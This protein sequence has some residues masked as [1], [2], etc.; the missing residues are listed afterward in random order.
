MRPIHSKLT[1]HSIFRVES[2]HSL[3]FP[4]SPLSTSSS[5]PSLPEP[6]YR[7]RQRQDHAVMSTPFLSST[8]I[9][10]QHLPTY[11]SFSHLS[12]PPS[13]PL[14]L[15]VVCGQEEPSS[16]L[17]SPHLFPSF[18][19]PLPSINYENPSPPYPPSLPKFPPLSPPLL[20]LLF[21]VIILSFFLSSFSPP[22][23]G[24]GSGPIKFVS[25][26]AAGVYPFTTFSGMRFKS[27]TKKHSVYNIP[28][29]SLSSLYFPF[30]TKTK[31]N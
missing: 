1:Y 27:S 24:D 21:F 2:P 31:K 12:L 23:S 14:F 28:P 15:S 30:N 17:S 11:S 26:K 5:Y 16:P 25:S 7:S 10:F 8:I 20:T 19:F 22:A 13:W 4:S 18:L 6:P 29:P 3:S 9:C